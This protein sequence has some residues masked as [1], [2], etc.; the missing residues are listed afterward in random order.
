MKEK[1][2]NEEQND[3]ERPKYL[4]KNNAKRYYLKS[5]SLEKFD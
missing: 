2:L 1:R 4:T 5:A 3:W